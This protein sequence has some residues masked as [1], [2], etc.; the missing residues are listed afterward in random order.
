MKST[1]IDVTCC[2]G[3]P[4]FWTEYIKKLG[5]VPHC[6]YYSGKIRYKFQYSAKERHPDCRVTNIVINEED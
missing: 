1:S 4:F 6:N 3:C 5:P 2:E